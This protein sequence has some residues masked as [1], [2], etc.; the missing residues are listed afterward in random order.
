[1]LFKRFKNSRID[2]PSIFYSKC[3]NPNCARCTLYREILTS[4]KIRLKRLQKLHQNINIF[5][6]EQSLI[7]KKEVHT[8]IVKN[9]NKSSSQKSR[10]EQNPEV[11]RLLETESVSWWFEKEYFKDDKSILETNFKC[12]FE[13]FK[14]L[15]ESEEANWLLNDTPNGRWRVCHL[16]NQGCIITTNCKLCPVTFNLVSSLPSVMKNNVFSNVAFSVIEPETFITEHYGPTNVRSRCH[17][18]RSN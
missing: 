11:F 15:Y 2:D 4:A 1:M 8:E 6:I 9:V 5:R 10:S 3:K 12:I 14:N 16:I 13:E 7:G 18:G 17:L